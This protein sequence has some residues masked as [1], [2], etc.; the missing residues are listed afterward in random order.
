MFEWTKD[1]TSEER[2]E[3]FYLIPWKPNVS[4]AWKDP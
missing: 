1:I 3:Q 4:L 2:L